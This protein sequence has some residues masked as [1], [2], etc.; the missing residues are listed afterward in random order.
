MKETAAAA[1]PKQSDHSNLWHWR[2]DTTWCL[3]NFTRNQNKGDRDLWS[4]DTKA[5]KTSWLWYK[6]KKEQ[7]SGGS[8]RKVSSVLC[9][10]KEVWPRTDFKFQVH[11]IQLLYKW[12]YW[13]SWVIDH[14]F[15]PFYFHQH[16]DAYCMYPCVGKPWREYQG[17]QRQRRL[18]F[19]WENITI[20][21][22]QDLF[23]LLPVHHFVTIKLHRTR[24]SGKITWLLRSNE[25]QFQQNWWPSAVL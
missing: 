18:I 4:E 10:K 11:F 23:P 24:S 1:R 15:L 14:S 13:H 2:R 25:E 21:S 3:G 19:T 8:E 7:A 5:E 17:M 9:E 6:Q 16:A 12:Y 20:L 22:S